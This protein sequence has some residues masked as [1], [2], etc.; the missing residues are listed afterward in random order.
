MID[1]TPDKLAVELCPHSPAWAEIAAEETARLKAAL[2]NVLLTVHHIGS[3]AIPGILAKPI[4]DLIPVVTDLPALDAQETAIRALGY[5]WYGEFGLAGRRYCTLS[6]PVTGKR[7]VQLHC[8][9]EGAEEM[10]R[11][12]VFR[13]Y[14]RAHPAIAKEYETEKLRAAALHPDDTL[15]YNAAKNEWIKR[16]EREALAWKELQQF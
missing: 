15:A 2:G 3:T 12:L 10:P 13:D 4:V 11:H 8:Y 9:A 6:D 7:K 5:K 1:P 14:L 16:A